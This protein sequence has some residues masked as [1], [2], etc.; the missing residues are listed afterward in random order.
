MPG[1]GEVE[2][3]AERVKNLEAGV[4][5]GVERA[6]LEQARGEGVDR[7]DVSRV[8]LSQGVVE[9]SLFGRVGGPAASL[10]ER[11]ADPRAQLARRLLGEGDRH[12]VAQL[13]VVAPHQ[14]DH[15]V[16]QDP[17]LAR[18]G[19]GLQEERGVELTEQ[20]LAHGLVGRRAAHRLL[21]LFA[22]ITTNALTVSRSKRS[23]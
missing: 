22:R 8:D 23:L 20:A 7:L 21:G 6:L 15:P 12:D 9:T 16:D 19:A 14:L 4:D 11:G 2:V 1:V 3:R 5:P 18:A 10:G 17:G 13:G